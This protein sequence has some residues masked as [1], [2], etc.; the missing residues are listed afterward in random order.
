MRKLLPLR[1]IR[2]RDPKGPVTISLIDV[3]TETESNV[4]V[5]LF[6]DAVFFVNER[7]ETLANIEVC[8]LHGEE[9]LRV[10]ISNGRNDS[11]DFDECVI[12]TAYGAT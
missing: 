2:R 6:G 9:H 7:G 3:D 8:Q 11:D 4:D 10:F 5:R 12:P 1:P